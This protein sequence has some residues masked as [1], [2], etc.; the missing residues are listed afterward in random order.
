MLTAG[1][2]LAAVATVALVISWSGRFG[3]R[4]RTGTTSLHRGNHSHVT[5][6]GRPK[7]AYATREAAEAHARQL[8][9]RQKSPMNV[10]QCESCAKWHVGHSK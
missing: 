8:S 7:V 2:L 4:N 9:A 1:V 6:R 3:G 5:S 10:Y